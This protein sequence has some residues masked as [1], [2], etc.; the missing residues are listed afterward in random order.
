M[1]VHG[2]VA[3]GSLVAHPGLRQQ[4]THFGGLGYAF[5]QDP[6][7]LLVALGRPLAISTAAREMMAVVLA[8]SRASAL[9]SEASSPAAISWSTSVGAGATSASQARTAARVEHR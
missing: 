4:V 7:G 3:S 5:E 6:E 2:I 1:A 8:G 9:R